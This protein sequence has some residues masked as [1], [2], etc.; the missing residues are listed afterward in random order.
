VDDQVPVFVKKQ[1]ITQ[2]TQMWRNT[3]FQLRMRHKVNKAIGSGPEVLKQIED[4]MVKSE[5]AL[6]V[7]QGELDALKEDVKA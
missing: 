3:L 7:L 1:L 4:D 5:S 2:E 6:E